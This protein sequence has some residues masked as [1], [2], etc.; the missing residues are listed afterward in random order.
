MMFNPYQIIQSKWYRNYS[1]IIIN[2]EGK[3]LR[4]Y[5]LQT[6]AIENQNAKKISLPQ[7]DLIPGI[8]F[9]RLVGQ[10]NQINFK[11]LIQ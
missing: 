1:L 3:V 8:Y 4:N 6:L 5:N 10:T 2:T 11:I 7:N 9:I